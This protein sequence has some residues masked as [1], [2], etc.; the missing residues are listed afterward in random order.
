ME[1]KRNT[2]NDEDQPPRKM[3]AKHNMKD[4]ASNDEINTGQVNI[5]FTLFFNTVFYSCFLKFFY[6]ISKQWYF[7]S[8]EGWTMG[9]YT[10]ENYHISSK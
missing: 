6:T 10:G 9:V 7:L 1:R 3:P 8:D 2:S 5:Y 4:N